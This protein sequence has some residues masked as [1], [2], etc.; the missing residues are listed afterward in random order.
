LFYYKFTFFN[1]NLSKY[2]AM[3]MKNPDIGIHFKAVIE[4]QIKC[5]LKLVH[6]DKID[7]KVKVRELRRNIKNIRSV[8]KLFKPIVA[9]TDFHSIDKQIGDINRSLTI[10]REASVNLKTFFSIEKLLSDN[11]SGETNELIIDELTNHY[12]KAYSNYD[13]AFDKIILNISFQLSK[14]REKIG[15][16]AT[17]EY[18]ESLLYLSLDKSFSKTVRLYTDSKLSL[19]TNMIHKWKICNKH[20]T[21]QIQFTALFHLNLFD[22]LIVDLEAITDLLGKDHDLAVLHDFIFGRLEEKIGKKELY[23]LQQVID[24]SRR[25]IQKEAFI[26]GNLVFS[27]H[28]NIHKTETSIVFERN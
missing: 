19:K 11:I 22:K 27:E 25:K 14:L 23:E 24:T 15:L 8:F 17:K 26:K 7:Q 6:D 10:Q 21:T 16:L 4:D 28:S 5:A 3:Q 12:N 1:V 2:N 18:T 9:E 20:L 13:N